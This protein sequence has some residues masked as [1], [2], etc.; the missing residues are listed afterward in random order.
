M[1][2]IKIEV[3][4]ES[5][6]LKDLFEAYEIKYTTAKEKELKEHIEENFTDVEY[7]A[8]EM[9]QELIGNYITELFEK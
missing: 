6:D 1:I 9:L 3:K 4:F 5:A 7:Q 2:K 8:E